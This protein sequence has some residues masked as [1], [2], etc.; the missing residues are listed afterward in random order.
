MQEAIRNVEL[1]WERSA[2]AL[3]RA[4]RSLGL[5]ARPPARLQGQYG[6]QRVEAERFIAGIFERAHGARIREFMPLILGMRAGDSRL[7]CGCGLR[8]AAREELFLE[9]YLDQPVEDAIA[10]A[11]GEPVARSAIVEVGNLAVAPPG[12][13]R[14][15]IVD[16][17]RSLAQAR[18]SWV[19]CTALP[20]LR[21]AFGRLQVPMLPLGRANIDRIAPPQRPDW[22]SYYDN[23]PL[24]IAIGVED[25]VRAIEALDRKAI[26]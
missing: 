1:P 12:S 15:L 16:L 22:G 14:E 17:T 5:T 20:A 6:L 4:A 2:G 7:I 11:G 8:D 18:R 23:L 25:A 13:A 19:V 10:G 24:V 21:N 3:A 9:R 26:A